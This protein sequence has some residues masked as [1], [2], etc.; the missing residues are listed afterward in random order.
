MDSTMDRKPGYRGENR[1]RNHRFTSLF[2]QA[3]PLVVGHDEFHDQSNGNVGGARR[4]G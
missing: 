1:T 4:A 3:G 2:P